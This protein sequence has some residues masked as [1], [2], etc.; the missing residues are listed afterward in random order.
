M[1]VTDAYSPVRRIPIAEIKVS[2]N[3][4]GKDR[5][6]DK[7]LQRLADSIQE[8]G[9]INPIT[10]A[11][12]WSLIAGLNR[13][14]ACRDILG[15]D[16]IEARV[17]KGAA[18]D[19]YELHPAV[20][21]QLQYGENVARKAMSATE[22]TELSRQIKELKG[23]TKAEAQERAAEI[24]GISAR[25][26][27]RVEAI[28]RAAQDEDPDVAAAATEALADIA[29]GGSVGGAEAKVKAARDQGLPEQDEDWVPPADEDFD[30][31]IQADDGPWEE[32][33]PDVPFEEP[34][35]PGAGI[36]DEHGLPVEVI[37]GGGDVEPYQDDMSR[38][39]RTALVGLIKIAEQ[40]DSIVMLEPGDLQEGLDRLTGPM[41]GKLRDLLST[42]N[43]AMTRRQGNAA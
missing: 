40:S 22:A 7:D 34:A 23:L 13:L 30:G 19:D 12:D 33:L 31:G 17:R 27:Q 5:F 4:P 25:S 21:M 15:M 38:D 39:V 14:R 35:D 10:V 41:Y 9:L 2:E 26:Q 42:L 8:V 18:E 3:H 29:D 16:S 20:T 1:D 6:T 28:E 11:S 43:D 36:V 24:S 32:S 37:D